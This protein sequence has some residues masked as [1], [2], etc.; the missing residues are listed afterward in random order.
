MAAFGSLLTGVT[1]LNTNQQM[2][3]IIGNN[4]A[5][6]NT[7]AYKS[8]SVSFEDLFYQ[9]LQPATPSTQLAGG[10]D[11]IQV[12]YGTKMGTISSSMSQGTLQPTGNQLDMGI[13]GD[14][15]FTES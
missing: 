4:L 6:S 5:N 8:Q 11:P 14:G 10:T 7:T 12:G 3:D 9:T 15:V 13:L 1:G 2:L